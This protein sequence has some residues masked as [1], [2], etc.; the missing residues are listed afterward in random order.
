MS[1]VTA[2]MHQSLCLGFPRA[3]RKLR[4]RKGINIRPDPDDLSCRFFSLYGGNDTGFTGFFIGNIQLIQIFHDFF[5]SMKFL[6]GQ[7]RMLVKIPAKLHQLFLKIFRHICL[8][9]FLTICLNFCMSFCV[10]ICLDIRFVIYFLM[11]IH[12]FCLRP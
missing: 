4:Q 6:P 5:L 1:V 8:N 2:G 11:I 9:I 7:L 3:V 12:C 10:D